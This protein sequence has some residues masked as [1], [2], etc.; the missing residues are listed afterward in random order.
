M[1]RTFNTKCFQSRTCPAIQAPSSRKAKHASFADIVKSY[2]VLFCCIMH[3]SNSLLQRCDGVRPI[4]GPC[5]A[6]KPTACSYE[7]VSEQRA[8]QEQVLAMEDRLQQLQSSRGIPLHH[9]YKPEA[10]QSELVHSA[11]NIHD[12][13]TEVL[14]ALLRSFIP[15]STDFGFFLH[16]SRFQSSVE[17]SPALSSAIYL[18]GSYLSPDKKSSALQ[19]ELL[20]RSLRESARGLSGNHPHKVLHTVQAEVL[21]A[22]YLFLQGRHTEGKYHISTATSIVLGAG[23]HKIRSGQQSIPG[24]GMVLPAP[25][26]ATEEVERVNALWTVVILNYCWTPT[27]G[28]WANGA[29]DMPEYRIDAPWPLDLGGEMESQFPS[30]L[31][32]GYTVQNFLANSNDGVRSLNALHSKAAVLFQQISLLLR[33]YSPNM[34]VRQTA[35]FQHDFKKLDS[36]ARGF[37]SELP[38]LAQAP[39]RGSVRKLLVIHTLAR[40][41]TVQLHSIFAGQDPKSQSFVLSIA[42]NIVVLLREAKLNDFPFIDPIM[43]IL[44][45]TTANLFIGEL[46]AMRTRAP[47]AQRS[48]PEEMIAAVETIMSVMSFFAPHSPLIDAQL[49]QIRRSVG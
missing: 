21:I 1:S 18:M 24:S 36:L 41:S 3:L 27:D 10:G 31:H 43:G 33:G 2:A 16:G 47:H 38:P 34:D 32:S 9:P 29:Y 46:A 48:R 6:S 7:G 42:Q 20:A 4:C 11:S 12:I 19:P 26:D 30:N 14:R 35:K 28:T 49:A 23:L 22:Q 44:W 40:I 15:Y 13:P 8:L 25:R 17:P 37:I 5:A 45:V 39:S